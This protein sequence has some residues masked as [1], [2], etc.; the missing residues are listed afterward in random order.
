MNDI[1]TDFIKKM[2]GKVVTNNESTITVNGT[3]I[4]TSGNI[5]GNL[6]NLKP[7][8]KLQKEVDIEQS[9][10]E[11]KIKLKALKSITDGELDKAFKELKIDEIIIATLSLK[12]AES[13]KRNANRIV[14]EALD[15]IEDNF[16]IKRAIKASVVATIKNAFKK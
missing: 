6:K 4:R 11:N 15:D 9:I 7:H 12:I 3:T 13:M 14:V 2:F 8:E 5:V 10:I 16:E 1:A